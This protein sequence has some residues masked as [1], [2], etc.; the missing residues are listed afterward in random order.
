MVCLRGAP[1]SMPTIA[2]VGF[3]EFYQLGR[4]LRCHLPVAGGRV[5]HLAVVFGFH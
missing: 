3:S 5:V 4:V 1:I 2:T